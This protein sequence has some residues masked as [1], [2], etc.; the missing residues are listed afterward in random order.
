MMME[1]LQIITMVLLSTFCLSG[2]VF[3]SEAST[4]LRNERKMLE[5]AL[6]IQKLLS[7]FK[8]DSSDKGGRDA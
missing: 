2:W 7:E 6:Q 5:K 4:K 1:T 3:F 8:G